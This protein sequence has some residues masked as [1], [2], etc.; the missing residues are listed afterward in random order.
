MML[1]ELKLTS[2]LIIKTTVRILPSAYFCHN[3]Y[4]SYK[5]YK[6]NECDVNDNGKYL[7]Q[8]D[9]EVLVHKLEDERNNQAL[10]RSSGGGAGQSSSAT[11]SPTK[12]LLLGVH[13]LSCGRYSS[14]AHGAR[15]STRCCHDL[16]MIEGAFGRVVRSTHS[17]FSS[18]FIVGLSQYTYMI[19]ESHCF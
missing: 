7:L 16:H 9:G 19:F 13:G 18:T 11:T 4:P 5:G 15:L 12:L 8:T 10:L 3:I 6:K 2:A 1:H 14:L 17:F